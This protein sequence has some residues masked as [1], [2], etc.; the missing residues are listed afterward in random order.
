MTLNIGD[1]VRLKDEHHSPNNCHCFLCVN[2]MKHA[3]GV[4]TNVWTDEDDEQSSIAEFPCGET[5]FRYYQYE[6][7]DV[8]SRMN[9]EKI[10]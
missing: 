3:V 4:I 8:V 1:L 9:D 2:N 10:F 5:V 7:L 6:S